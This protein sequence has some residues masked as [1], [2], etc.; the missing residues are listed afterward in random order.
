MCIIAIAIII[1]IQNV[2][3]GMQNL[4]GSAIG[5]LNLRHCPSTFL[6]E[7]TCCPRR[8]SGFTSCH[9]HITMETVSWI[10]ETTWTYFMSQTGRTSRRDPLVQIHSSEMR[11]IIIKLGDLRLKNLPRDVIGGCC[12][13]RMLADS[14]ACCCAQVQHVSPPTVWLLRQLQTSEQKLS[15]AC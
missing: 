7:K 4:K 13:R 9:L 6:H 11:H 15:E 1:S 12:E 10:L 2:P 5:A 8:F 14:Y 3:H